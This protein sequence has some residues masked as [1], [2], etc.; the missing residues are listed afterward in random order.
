MHYVRGIYI[1]YRNTTGTQEGRCPIRTGRH[2]SPDQ[3][4]GHT[5]ST[6]ASKVDTRQT[7]THCTCARTS[8]MGGSTLRCADAAAGTT[9][10]SLEVE[11]GATGSARVRRLYPYNPGTTPP[12]RRRAAPSVVHQP[13]AF[14]ARRPRPA[15]AFVLA[16]AG[17]ART[18]TPGG[19]RREQQVPK[20]KDTTPRP[21]FSGLQAACRPS[22]RDSVRSAAHTRPP[23][24]CCTPGRSKCHP[25]TSPRNRRAR[26][27]VR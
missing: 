22:D 26:H 1:V 2:V 13:A 6:H 3:W 23:C 18:A 12:W 16:L 8:I 10:P 21:P 17:G 9:L 24:R 25:P 4:V 14:A 11:C 15:L 5:N 19:G 20:A 27:W 7:D